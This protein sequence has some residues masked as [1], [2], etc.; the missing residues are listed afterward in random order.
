MTSSS[1]RVWGFFL[2]LV[3]LVSASP[4]HAFPWNVRHG[5][6]NCTACHLSPGGGGVL[7]AYDRELAKEIQ[8][9]KSGENEAAFLYGAVKTPEW[10]D[11][12]GD[13]RYIQ[14]FQDTPTSFS[15][16]SFWMQSDLEAGVH[17]GKITLVGTAGWKGNANALRNDNDFISRRHYAMVTLDDRFT[18]RGGRFYPVFGLMQAEHEDATR[19]PIGFDQ[20]ME[21]YNLEFSDQ[22]ENGSL[23]VSPIFGKLRGDRSAD[24]KGLAASKY[25][26][27][28]PNTRVGVSGLYG[29]GFY[30]SYENR[31]LAGPSAIMNLSKSL[32]WMAEVDFERRKVIGADRHETGLYEVQRLGYEPMQGLILSGRQDLQRRVVGDPRTSAVTLGPQVDFYPRP[33]FDLQVALARVFLPENTP[34]F[35]MWTGVLHFYL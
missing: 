13:L 6:P 9:M 14:I 7:S 35:W 17:L 3:F 16:R 23:F 27:F 8:S 5:Y 18:L 24:E 19:G 11:A 2:G 28:G 34:N 29:K 21:S 20:G 15:G 1:V 12:G 10:L 32:F 25:F 26:M 31:I 33:H 4:A 30:N 22:N